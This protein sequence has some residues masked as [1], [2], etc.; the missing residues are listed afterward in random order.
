[1]CRAR[2]RSLEPLPRDGARRRTRSGLARRAGGGAGPGSALGSSCLSRARRG[3]HRAA[4]RK[5]DVPRCVR[6]VHIATL[7]LTGPSRRS[8]GFS[9]RFRRTT[10][11][12]ASMYASTMRSTP[13]RSTACARI[14]ARSSRPPRP[15]PRR[16]R[17]CRRRGSPVLPS[18]MSSGIEPRSNAMT[19]VPH[20]IASTTLKPNGSSKPMRCSSACAPPSS[21]D[22]VP[23]PTAPMNAPGR[24]RSAAR[25]ARRSSAGPARCRR[26]RAAARTRAATSIAS[27]CPCRDGCDRRTAGS[28]RAPDA[29]RRRR[30]RCRGGSSRG[31][32]GGD[33]RSASLI[34][35]YACVAL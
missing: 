5:P 16:R 30:C 3:L 35:T 22:R 21:S 17:R 33:A 19:G 13:N 12:Y 25:P 2:A 11:S 9:S 4:P 8:K 10:V 20:A 28:R 7:P 6:R 23:A 15:R 29:A 27:P 26:S 24:R 34:A 31:S 14:A 1:M 32:R 18:S